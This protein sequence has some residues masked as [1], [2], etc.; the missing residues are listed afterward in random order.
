MTTLAVH[1]TNRE[2]AMAAEC[3]I[4]RNIASIIDG[5]ENG[6]GLDEVDGGWSKHVEGACGEVA[7]AKA[8]GRFWS[9]TVNVFNAADIGRMIGVRTRSRHDYDLNIRRN[10]KPDHAYVLVTGLAPSFVV[11]GYIIGADARRD[12]WL[13]AYGG[14]PAAWF[15]PQAALLDIDSLR[16][17][18]AS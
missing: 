16:L 18:A 5:R 9:P 17:R 12:E 7:V 4:M 2:M 1:L 6:H 15:V 10:D 11:R 8:L 13:Q 3:G 14:R